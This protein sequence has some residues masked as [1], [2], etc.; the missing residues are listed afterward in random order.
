[1]QVY[2]GIKKLSPLKFIDL[3][4]GIGGFYRVFKEF[5]FECVFSSEINK[6]ARDV[7]LLNYGIEPHGDI[8]KIDPKI[9]PD[10]D[11]LCAGFPC[12]SFSISGKGNGFLDPRGTLFFD[13]IKIAKIKKTKVLLL[14]NVSNLKN[15]DNGNTFKIIKNTLEKEGYS[16][17]EKVFN[18]K[19]FGLAQNRERII[20]IASRIGT[21]DISKVK[22]FKN[23][24]FIKDILEKNIDFEYLKKEEYVIIPKDKWK[25]QKS[26]LI[27]CGYRKKE[28]RKG[29]QQIKLEHSRVHKQPNRIYHINGVHPTISSQE[30]S[31]R[32]FIYDGKKVRKLTQRECYRLQGFPD[33]HIIHKSKTEAYRQIGNSVP[34]NLIK[35][36]VKEIVKQIFK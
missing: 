1:M 22:I 26:G 7:Y 36:V 23:K 13:I 29:V 25:T 31:G 28:I 24:V 9:I 17:Y 19:D 3:F 30:S 2:R 8:T 33:N 16:V 5:G 11:I 34:L 6:A 27:F 12:Q 35:Y 4:S 20:I 10:H 15:H 14:E 21:F 32:F 18:S